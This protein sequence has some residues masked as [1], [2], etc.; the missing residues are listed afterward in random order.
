MTAIIVRNAKASTPT[1]VKFL[2]D[3]LQLTPAE[4]LKDISADF[5]PAIN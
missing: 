1:S 4:Y 3:V 2:S 5:V